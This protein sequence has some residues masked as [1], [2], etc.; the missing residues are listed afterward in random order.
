M[1][2]CVCCV[3][4]FVLC[5]LLL[6]CV[7]VVVVVVLLCCCLLLVVVL[8]LC[9]GLV[10]LSFLIKSQTNQ[11]I[12]WRLGAQLETKTKNTKQIQKQPNTNRHL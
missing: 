5:L 4:A 2:L 7:C 6:C 11:T 3:V 8:L 10:F 9:C 1:L 12:K